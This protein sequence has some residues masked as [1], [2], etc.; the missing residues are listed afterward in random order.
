[1]SSVGDIQKVKFNEICRFFGPDST[2]SEIADM[3]DL[4]DIGAVPIINENNQLM[5]VV[6]ERDIVRKLV[7]NGRDSDLVTAKDIMTSEVITV[8][9]KTSQ[10]DA[11]KLM[12]T[13]KIR[14][15]P[16]V[17]DSQKLINFISHR[18]IVDPSH[19]SNKLNFILLGFAAIILPAIF[20]F[21]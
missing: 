8:T 4:Q 9:K 20:I 12:K 11:L 13:N 5:G 19:G 16:I 14:H 18:D 10:I 17:D 15:L 1:M 21:N 7:K 3:M 2:V 6:S